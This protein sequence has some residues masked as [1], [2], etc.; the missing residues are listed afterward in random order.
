MMLSAEDCAVVK[1]LSLGY[2]VLSANPLSFPVLL[3]PRRGLW[4]HLLSFLLAWGGPL[5]DGGLLSLLKPQMTSHYVA[6]IP[7]FE[8]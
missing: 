6:A 7:K 8:E 1:S 5:G 2:L 4:A 3:A